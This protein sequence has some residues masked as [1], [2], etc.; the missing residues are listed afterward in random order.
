MQLPY[1]DSEDIPLWVNTS[2]RNLYAAG[3]IDTYPENKINGSTHITRAEMVRMLD[4]AMRT[5]DFDTSRVSQTTLEN[6]TNPQ[7]TATEIPHDILGY[8]TIES[9]GTVSYTHLDVYKRQQNDT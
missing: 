7:A 4:K 5:Y 1:S 8:L 2:V 3:V 6:Y 9:I